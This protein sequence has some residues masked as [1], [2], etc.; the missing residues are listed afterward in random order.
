MSVPK[1]FDNIVNFMSGAV[2]RIFGLDDD[3]YPNTGVQPYSG[4]PVDKKHRS[5]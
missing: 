1:I 4:D 5:D 2:S 3:N